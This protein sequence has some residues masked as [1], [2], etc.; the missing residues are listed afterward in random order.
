MS[1]HLRQHYVIK[2]SEVAEWLD[3]EPSTWWIVH[4]DSRLTRIVDFPCPSSE[5]SEALRRY[6]KNLFIYAPKPAAA[7]SQPS[8]Q[9][10][11]W[12]GL[13]ELSDRDNPEKS[14]TFFL[15][16]SDREDD[17]MLAEYPSSRLRELKP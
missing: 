9:A 5:L 3:Q 13:N 14:R 15:S 10:I 12:Q 8:G 17:W 6:H 2:P 1:P 16:W 7:G 4:G 11:K